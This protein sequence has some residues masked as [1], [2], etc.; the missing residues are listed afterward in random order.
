MSAMASCIGIDEIW[1]DLSG[2]IFV[3]LFVSYSKKE[4]THIQ[5]KSNQIWI[6]WFG[7]KPMNSFGFVKEQINTTTIYA[8]ILTILASGSPLWA[9]LS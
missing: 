1:T 2:Y 8:K 5:N 4:C 6:Y 9:G 3:Q 7:L